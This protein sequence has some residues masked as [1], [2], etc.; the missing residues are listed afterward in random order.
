MYLYKN[1]HEPFLRSYTHIYSGTYMAHH[2]ISIIQSDLDDQGN[3]KDSEW[4]L[5]KH[6]PVQFHKHFFKIRAYKIN[7][8]NTP[9]KLDDGVLTIEAS[10]GDFLFGSITAGDIQFHPTDAYDRPNILGPLDLVRFRADGLSSTQQADFNGVN[11]AVGH[12]ITLKIEIHS[13]N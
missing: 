1:I 11:E 6:I 4:M 7:D 13:Y 2:H 3:F 8:L 10:D 9:V 5:S 12:R